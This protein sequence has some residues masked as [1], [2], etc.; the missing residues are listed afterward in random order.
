M[1]ALKLTGWSA[2]LVLAWSLTACR[3]GGTGDGS[4]R[5]A[6]DR[7]E[8]QSTERQMKTNKSLV[9]S[10][11]DESGELVRIGTLSF[12][13]TKHVK[14]SPEGSGPSVEELKEAWKEISKLKELTWKQSRPDVVDGR[15]VT[16]IIAVPVKP[17]EP[18]YIYAVMN[19]LERKYGYTVDRAD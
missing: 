5:A 16:R 12:D 2:V 11:S 7:N 15:K 3:S 14:L 13:D 6:S 19:T 4:H 10:A 18:N 8:I 1:F 17:G 9:I